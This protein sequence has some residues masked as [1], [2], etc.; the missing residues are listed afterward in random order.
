MIEALIRLIID[1][2]SR[3]GVWGI[4]F[5]MTL[6]SA[7]IPIP[8]EVTMPFAGFLVSLGKFNSGLFPLWGR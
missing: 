1:F 5:L 7:L 6:E 3:F 8:S 2:I 4:F